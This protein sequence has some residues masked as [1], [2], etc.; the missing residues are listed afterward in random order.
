MP[1][2]KQTDYELI[3]VAVDPNLRD[4]WEL[5]REP[6]RYALPR[7]IASIPDGVELVHYDSDKSYYGRKWSQEIIWSS[8]KKGGIFISD[9]VEDNTAFMEFVSSKNL[10]FNLVEFEN[11]FVGIIKKF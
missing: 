6:D 3:G 7:A 11:K 2:L 4:Y 10:K 5:K 9:D 8:L 1:M